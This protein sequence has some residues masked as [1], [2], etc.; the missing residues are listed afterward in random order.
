MPSPDMRSARALADDVRTSVDAIIGTRAGF[1]T[2]RA[3]AV[4]ATHV[5][6]RRAAAL[7]CIAK[8]AGKGSAADQCQAI[9]EELAKVGYEI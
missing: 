8:I 4:D 7:E 6:R 9:Y 5:L 2:Y 3:V 1:K